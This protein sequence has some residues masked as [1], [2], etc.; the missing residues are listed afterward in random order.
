MLRSVGGY[1]L[2]GVVVAVTLQLVPR[3]KV[4]RVVGLLSF[5]EM[6]T[7]LYVPRHRLNSFMSAV[8]EDFLAH[9]VNFI[10]GTIRLIQRDNDAFCRRAR[11]APDA[12]ECGR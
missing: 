3:Q 10:Y 2:F 6:I 4:E 9:D 1:G 5:T 8:S 12:P 11:G 7:E